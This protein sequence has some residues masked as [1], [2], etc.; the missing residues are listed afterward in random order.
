MSSNKTDFITLEQY[1]S[2]SV[3]TVKLI[4]HKGNEELFLGT[5]FYFC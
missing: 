1:L 4:G 3:V 2:C 5:G